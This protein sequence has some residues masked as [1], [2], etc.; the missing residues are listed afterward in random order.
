MGRQVT[1]NAGA[2]H[3]RLSSKNAGPDLAPKNATTLYVSAVLACPNLRHI[4]IGPGLVL[5]GKV[6]SWSRLELDISILWGHL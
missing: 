5:R 4:N 3:V 1:T 2:C 6:N